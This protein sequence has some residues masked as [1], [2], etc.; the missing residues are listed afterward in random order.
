MSGSALVG[1]PPANQNDFY[2]VRGFYR[3]YNLPFMNPEEGIPVLKAPPGAPHGQNRGPGII[4]SYSVLIFLLVVI[5]STRLA[6]RYFKKNLKWGPD[7]YAIILGASGA[8]AWIAITIAMVLVG[9][10]GKH[11]YDITYAEFNWF[12]DVS[13]SHGLRRMII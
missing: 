13:R 12:I 4:G 7:D 5:T 9:G 1:N 8:C 10:S 3:S 11:I 2:I 6:L